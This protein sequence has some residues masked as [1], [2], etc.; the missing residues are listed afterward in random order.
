MDQQQLL[1]GIVGG[2]IGWLIGMAALRLV[3]AVFM[4]RGT[5]Y[6][7]PRRLREMQKSMETLTRAAMGKGWD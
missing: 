6:V 7:S 2:L 5:Y 3:W 4:P 1:V